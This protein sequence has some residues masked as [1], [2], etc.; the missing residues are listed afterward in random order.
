MLSMI[1]EE[2]DWS[3]FVGC[4]VFYKVVN[5]YINLDVSSYNQFYSDSEGYYLRG[6]N[7]LI[8]KKNYA[9]TD[10]FKFNFF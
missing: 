6:R 9:R 5:E 1:L 3:F 10:T 8:L 4:F 7:D 2:K